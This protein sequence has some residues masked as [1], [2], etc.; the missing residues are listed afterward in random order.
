MQRNNMT[1]TITLLSAQRQNYGTTHFFKS[2]VQSCMKTCGLLAYL[3]KK[4]S[5]K[6][7]KGALLSKLLV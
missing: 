1:G 6:M 3:K 2:L 7:C 4:K 5:M